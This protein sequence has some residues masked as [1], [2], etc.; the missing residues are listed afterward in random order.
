MI[1]Q[2]VGKVLPEVVKTGDQGD[3]S[4]AYTELVL[5]L[6]EALKQQQTTM[7]QQQTTLREQQ[8]AMAEQQTTLKQQQTAN[9]QQQT[10]IKEQQET[11]SELRERLAA[12]EQQSGLL[13][14]STSAGAKQRTPAIPGP[15]G[16]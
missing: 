13:K 14:V 10:A 6:I 7:E 2:E 12:V 15:S 16:L 11:M 5:V 3:K 9:Q 8:M 4:V 1:A